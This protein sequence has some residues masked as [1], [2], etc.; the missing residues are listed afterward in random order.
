MFLVAIV[1]QDGEIDKDCSFCGLY[2]FE[3]ET[4]LDAHPAP[5]HIK[6]KFEPEQWNRMR[7]FDQIARRYENK[8]GKDGS[9]VPNMRLSF[10]KNTGL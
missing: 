8:I 3:S 7:Q 10:D 2:S 6:I 1:N 9:I 5:E 4:V